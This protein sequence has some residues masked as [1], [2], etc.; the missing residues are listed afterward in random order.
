[1][2]IILY[3][4]DGVHRTVTYLIIRYYLIVFKTNYLFTSVIANKK[5]S[6]LSYILLY[7]YIF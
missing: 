5:K 6:I 4:N 2:V 1:M 7:S 3:D